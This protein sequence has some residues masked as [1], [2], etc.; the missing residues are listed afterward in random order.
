MGDFRVKIRKKSRLIDESKCIACGQCA[1]K[2]PKKV[3]DE[4]NM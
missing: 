4:F 3:P 2:C 1:E